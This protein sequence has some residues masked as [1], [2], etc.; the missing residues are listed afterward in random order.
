MSIV[1]QIINVIFHYIKQNYIEH[2][3]T[4]NID[5]IPT[6]DLYPFLEDTYSKHVTLNAEGKSKIHL[7]VY[8]ILD[9]YTEKQIEE[10]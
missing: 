1:N 4:N 7:Y 8:E 2:L 5:I 6:L 9:T 10:Q 3:E